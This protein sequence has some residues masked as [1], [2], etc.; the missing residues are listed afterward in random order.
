[1]AIQVPRYLVPFHPK[2][3]PHHFVDVL[4]IGGGIAGLR[5]AMG[6][7]PR[8][9]TLVV[10]KDRLQESSST[11]AQGG[12]AG[13]ARPGGTGSRTTIADTL[14]AGA[15]ICD[16]EVVE[17]VVRQ[18]PPTHPGT[19]RLGHR[20]R[21]R[22]GRP[23]PGPRGRPQPPPHCTRAGRRH[24]Q[25]DINAGDD[26]PGDPATRRTGLARHVHHRSADRRGPLPRRA[27]LARAP[28]PH[29]SSGPRRP[30]SVPAARARSTARRPTPPWRPATATPSP[31]A[32]GRSWWTWSSCSSTPPCSTSPA[33]TAAS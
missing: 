2:Q 20:V 1:M 19:D 11:Y 4:V 31:T 24:R 27:R 17:M 10:T 8:L 29:G 5:A 3:I 9:S 26:R 32:P 33:A 13:C 14:T 7:D 6:V 16:R 15:G 21:L 25:R 28:R 22:R 12:I 30:C 23:L 18:A